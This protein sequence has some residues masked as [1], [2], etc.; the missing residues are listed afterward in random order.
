[1]TKNRK[2]QK[3]DYKRARLIIIVGIVLLVI[4][5]VAFWFLGSLKQGN[6]AGG[7]GGLSWLWLLCCFL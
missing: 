7:I 4:V 2:M 1:M 6:L 3:G 5:T